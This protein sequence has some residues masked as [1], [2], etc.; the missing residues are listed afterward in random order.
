[1]RLRRLNDLIEEGAADLS[2][3]NY[4]VLVDGADRMLDMPR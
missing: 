2:R 3:V 4:L 1:M